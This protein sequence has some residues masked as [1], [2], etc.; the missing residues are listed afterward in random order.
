MVSMLESL[1][2]RKLLSS[3]LSNGTLSIVGTGGADHVDITKSGGNLVVD[4]HNGT[5]P[6]S[7][8]AAAVNLIKVDVKDGNDVVTVAADVTNNASIV[9]GNGA[10]SL[11]GGGGND[12]IS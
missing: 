12:S 1:E 7:Y 9:G 5:S 8:A 11:T 3:S 6:K 2:Y 10:D 4:E